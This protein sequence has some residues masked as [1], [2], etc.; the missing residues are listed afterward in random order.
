MLDDA[1]E[2]PL[3]DGGGELCQVDVGDD[4]EGDGR[5]MRL[6]KLAEFLQGRRRPPGVVVA[7]PEMRDM[8]GTAPSRDFAIESGPR[9]ASLEPTYQ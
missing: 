7:P 4:R 9:V 8:P 2:P 6:R 1:D 5:D 3:D